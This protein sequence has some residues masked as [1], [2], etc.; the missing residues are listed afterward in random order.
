MI[1]CQ[2]ETLE[3]EAQIRAMAERLQSIGAEIS[4]FEFSAEA[5]SSWIIIGGTKNK[6]IKFHYEGKESY[7]RFCDASKTPRDYRDFEHKSFKTWE[8]EDPM[9]FV[10]QALTELAK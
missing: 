7:L 2:K 3:F 9:A 4:D 6:K 8:G 5:F 1:D 10:E